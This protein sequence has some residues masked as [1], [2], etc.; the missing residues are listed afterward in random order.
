MSSEEPHD[1]SISE[2][3]RLIES[4]FFMAKEVVT[5][6]DLRPSE[7]TFS[8]FHREVPWFHIDFFAVVSVFAYLVW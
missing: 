7:K 6:R 3:V 5:H 8:P 2:R 1:E 4:A